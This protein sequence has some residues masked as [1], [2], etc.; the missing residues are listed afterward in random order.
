V[1]DPTERERALAVVY[2]Q[3]HELFELEGPLEPDMRLDDLGLDSLEVVEALLALQQKLFD[4]LGEDDDEVAL[5]TEGVSLVQVGDL[6]DVL[7][8]L[9][10]LRTPRLA[11]I[12][13]TT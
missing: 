3:M 1:A 11:A 6:A 2:Q 4:E 10:W 13:E 8:D 5:P 7:V 9:G 12:L